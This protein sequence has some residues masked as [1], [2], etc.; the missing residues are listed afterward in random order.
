[1]VSNLR[2]RLS[3]REFIKI[4]VIG[5]A[6]LSSA[7]ALARAVIKP[8][9]RARRAAPASSPT[10]TA[11]A[12]MAATMPNGV[13]AGDVSQD[14]AVLWARTIAGSTV[15]FTYST[16]PNFESSAGTVTGETTGAMIP[17]KVEIGGLQ[18]GT[19]Y[20][21]R[22]TDASGATVA[23]RFRTLA[24]PGIKQGLRFGVSGDWRGELRP[25]VSLSNIAGRDLDF[26]LEHGDTIYGDVPSLDL[27]HIAESLAD[28]RIK[29]NEVYSE[30]YGRN[31][32]ADIRAA[33]PVYAVID[34]HEVRNDFAGGAAPS[35]DGRFDQGAAYINQTDLYRNGLQAFQEYN[36]MRHEIYEGTGD[37]RVDGR[38][39]LYRCRT[40]GSTAAMFILDS[41]SFRD[42]EMP[43]I[44]PLQAINPFAVVRSLV[45]MFT[46]GRTMLGKPQ[47]DEFKRDLMAA[48]EAGITWKF[49]M[50]PEPVQHMGWFGGVDRWEGYAPERTEV[51]RF[52]EDNGIRNVVFVSADVHTTFINNLTYQTEASA[53]TSRPTASRSAPNARR[54]R[55]RPGRSSSTTP[56]GSACCHSGGTRNTGTC[57]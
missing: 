40:F 33:M 24:A 35:S 49:V 18:P 47:L 14:A 45:T 54:I 31:V 44:P 11:Q 12:T 32:W 25:Y 23:G 7:P 39:K 6:V 9:A 37:P 17:V 3:R 48:H 30:R 4:T 50:I 27:D 10:I 52:I 1:M 15:T 26:F 2:K 55:R 46:P 57:R 28:F 13:A 34:D 36:P 43:Q 53:S 29:H 38:P 41:R 5:A 20:Y 19:T 21:Y 42:E 8:K 22:A 56:R 51:L 16:D